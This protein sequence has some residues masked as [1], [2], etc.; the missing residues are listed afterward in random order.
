MLIHCCLDNHCCTFG[1]LIFIIVKRNSLYNSLYILTERSLK[2]PCS[3]RG[4]GPRVFFLSLSLPLSLSHSL[5]LILWSVE[6]PTPTPQLTLLPRLSR[7]P[8]EGALCLCE[9]CKPCSRVLLVLCVNQ[10]ILAL[11]SLSL[12]Y[13]R[14]QTTKFRPIKG[15]QQKNSKEAN[16]IK[17]ISLME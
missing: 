14:L 9:Q 15:P 5:W 16:T 6:T 1:F 11:F 8:Q 13:L 3:T 12:S 10:G 4:L 7:P 2:H 17:Q